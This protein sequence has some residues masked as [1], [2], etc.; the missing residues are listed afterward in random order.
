MSES[1]VAQS[2]YAHETTTQ[3][4]GRPWSHQSGCR[5]YSIR[6]GRG[7]SSETGAQGHHVYLLRTKLFRVWTVGSVAIGLHKP[8]RKLNEIFSSIIL[9]HGWKKRFRTSGG[10]LAQCRDSRLVRD[11]E[12]WIFSSIAGKR[13]SGRVGAHWHSART[14]GLF[15]MRRAEGAERLETWADANTDQHTQV[16]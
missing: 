15:E 3:W 13:D 12:G 7:I 2:C 4:R 6:R 5:D 11:A 1:W 8:K 10:T 9:E 14:A 16:R